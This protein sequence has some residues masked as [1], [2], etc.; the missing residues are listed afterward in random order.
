MEERDAAMAGEEKGER[1]Q[2]TISIPPSFW[3]VAPGF[4][5]WGGERAR[6]I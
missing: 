4:F 3:P 6:V 2:E 5:V 1:E